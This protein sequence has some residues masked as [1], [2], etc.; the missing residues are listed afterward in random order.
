M[1]GLFVV[2]SQQTGFVEGI[3]D[4]GRCP[5]DEVFGFEHDLVLCV[6]DFVDERIGHVFR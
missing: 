4:H 5:V 1:T 3:G 6:A 2:I